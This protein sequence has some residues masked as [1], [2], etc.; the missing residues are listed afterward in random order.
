[1]IS[2]ITKGF[3]KCY[4]ELPREVRANARTAYRLGL[5]NPFHPSLQFKK[6]SQRQPIYSVRIGLGWRALGLLEDSCIYWF[7]V[8]SH[9]EYDHLLRRI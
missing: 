6:V 2:R 5:Q 9:D 3:R 1:V 4:E 8:G 7:W